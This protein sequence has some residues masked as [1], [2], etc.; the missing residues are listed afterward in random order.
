MDKDPTMQGSDQVNENYNA[1]ANM[2]DEVRQENGTVENNVEQTRQYGEDEF[3]D[4][5]YAENYY[6]GGGKEAVEKLVANGNMV[7]NLHSHEATKMFEDAEEYRDRYTYKV[8]QIP[9]EKMI[10]GYF[11]PYQRQEM[12]N[13]D[14]EYGYLVMPIDYDRKHDLSRARNCYTPEAFA[15]S[16]VQ[17]EDGTYRSKLIT[18]LVHCSELPAAENTKELSMEDAP[19]PP[20]FDSYENEGAAIGALFNHLWQYEDFLQKR[21]KTGR[22]CDFDKVVRKPEDAEYMS[23]G[24]P[25]ST[26]FIATVSPDE[27]DKI[28][29]RRV[30]N[31][32]EIARFEKA[33][34]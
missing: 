26:Y 34:S 5:S 9:R 17:Q 27:P 13:S 30:V 6:N 20:E 2:A 29:D 19:Q 22:V 21:N 3:K 32:T 31:K 24:K 11:Y 1:W 10:N 14:A 28:Y 8:E 33:N 23:G 12:L 4:P 7:I 16:F 15:K 18:K 25:E